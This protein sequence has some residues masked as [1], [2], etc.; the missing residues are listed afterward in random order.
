MMEYLLPTEQMLMHT[1]SY[2]YTIT[3][4]LRGYYLPM[5]SSAYLAHTGGIL[6]VGLYLRLTA[7]LHNC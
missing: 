4:E 7:I 2:Q 6:E 1:I 5:A 3:I